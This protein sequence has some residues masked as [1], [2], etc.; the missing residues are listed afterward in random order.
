MQSEG[1]WRIREFNHTVGHVSGGY[2]SGDEFDAD[3]DGW[4]LMLM[5]R[6]MT[7]MMKSDVDDDVDV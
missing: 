2:D 4:G 1:E 5:R 7:S 6:T 3:V